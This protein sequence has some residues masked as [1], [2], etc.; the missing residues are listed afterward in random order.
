M[1]LILIKS[2]AWHE[3]LFVMMRIGE[4]LQQAETEDINKP[5]VLK[6]ANIMIGVISEARPL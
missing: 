6:Q 3:Y 2:E 5:E 1:M 4:I